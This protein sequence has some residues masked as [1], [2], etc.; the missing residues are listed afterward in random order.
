MACVTPE[1]MRRS[2]TG[3]ASGAAQRSHGKTA[4]LRRGHLRRRGDLGRCAGHAPLRALP[5]VAVPGP[6]LAGATGGVRPAVD[7]G[8]VPRLGGAGAG[9]AAAALSRL[10]AAAALLV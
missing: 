9:V 5:A 1:R 6:G 7:P 2:G 10:V 3:A 4:R 8:V